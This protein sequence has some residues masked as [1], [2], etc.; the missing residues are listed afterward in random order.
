APSP[1]LSISG[2]ASFAGGDAS[3]VMSRGII[4][5]GGNFSQSGLNSSSSFS[6]TGMSLMMTGTAAQTITFANPD[7]TLSPFGC[8]S[9]DTPAG[10]KFGSDVVANSVD[11][12]SGTVTE[13]GGAHTV[14]IR[15]GGLTDNV[16]AAAGTGGAWRPSNTVFTGSQISLPDTMTTN[17]TFM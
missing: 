5:L 13:T 2:D 15:F 16:G 8:L 6:A 7:S 14:V 1:K 3:G 17:V 11:I 4:F 9:L 10:V 12:D